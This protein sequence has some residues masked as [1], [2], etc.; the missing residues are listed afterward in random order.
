MEKKIP[1]TKLRETKILK[2]HVYKA[3]KESRLREFC[4][5]AG[6]GR[7]FTIETFCRGCPY[8][9]ICWPKGVG[10]S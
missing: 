7:K 4:F 10:K 6:Y 3:V 9:G 2:H 5:G 1:I 8:Q